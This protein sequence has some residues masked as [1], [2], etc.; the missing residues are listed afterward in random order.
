MPPS[1]CPTFSFTVDNP[2]AADSWMDTLH[3]PWRPMLHCYR[4]MVVRADGDLCLSPRLEIRCG[5]CCSPVIFHKEGV[6]CQTCMAELRGPSDLTS[7]SCC[8]RFHGGL[9]AFIRRLAIRCRSSRKPRGRI[10]RS[11]D[12]GLPAGQMVQSSSSLRRQASSSQAHGPEL[13]PQLIIVIEQL[14]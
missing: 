8:P 7:P 13:A 10:A 3:A 5:C 4:S 1:R 11:A 9:P 2:G 12:E 6:C 14:L